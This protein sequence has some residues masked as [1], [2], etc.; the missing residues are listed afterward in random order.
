MMCWYYLDAY[1]LFTYAAKSSYFLSKL[2][3]VFGLS[4]KEARWGPLYLQVGS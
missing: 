4:N 1:S 2:E 3:D